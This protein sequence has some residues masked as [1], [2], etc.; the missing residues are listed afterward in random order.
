MEYGLWA[1]EFV[2][3]EEEEAESKY[4]IACNE[5]TSM[6][7][8][9]EHMEYAPASMRQRR[10]RRKKNGNRQRAVQKIGKREGRQYGMKVR[11]I[12]DQ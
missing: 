11:V 12:Q 5:G 2:V 9:E 4:R 8:L 1:C 10:R 3:C 6:E 7:I